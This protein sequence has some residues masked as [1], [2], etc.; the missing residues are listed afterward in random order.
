MR[1]LSALCACAQVLVLLPVARAEGQTSAAGPVPAPAPA[2]GLARAPAPAP[3]ASPL[4]PGQKPTAAQALALSKPSEWRALDPEN[5][6]YLELAAG[7]VVIELAPAF[8]PSHVAN[9]K[10]LAREGY[11]DG[12]A[13]LRSQDN[14]VAQWGDPTEKRPMKTG[15]PKLPAEFTAPLDPKLAFTRLSDGDLYAPVVGHSLGFPVAHDPE[16]KT[17]WLTHCYG[18]VGA[19]RDTDADSGSG[20]ELYA[21]NGHAPRHLD[22]NV[23]L[24][25][26]VVWGMELLSTIKRGTEMRELQKLLDE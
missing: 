6:L 10:A 12:L 5:S 1:R 17:M 2:P 7:R 4:L 3:A 14:Y 8:A 19:G 24:L 13:V 16:G 22:R 15:K 23:T 25:G 21:V 18:M 11:F 9:V 20:S 26:R